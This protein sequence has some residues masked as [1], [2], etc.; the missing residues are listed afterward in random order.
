MTA[1]TRFTDSS[2]VTT[3]AALTP[4]ADFTNGMNEGAACSPAIG[5]NVG[6][7]DL[8]GTDDQFTLEDQDAVTREPQVGQHIGGDGLG[9]GVIGKGTEGVGVVTNDVSG[10]GTV[11]ET[12][13]ATLTTLVTGWVSTP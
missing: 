3:L 4:D 8:A 6:V 2:T 7:A 10:D 11:V 1:P 13:E 12:G 9:D 5:I